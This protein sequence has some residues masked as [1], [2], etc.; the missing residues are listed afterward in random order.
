MRNLSVPIVLFTVVIALSGCS[1]ISPPVMSPSPTDV[2]SVRFEA[3]VYEVQVPEN[4]IAELDA[5][6]FEAH[7]AT[8]QNLARLLEDFGETK[9]LYK[10]DKVINIYGDSIVLETMRPVITGGSVRR[11]EQSANTNPVTYISS[12]LRVNVAAGELRRPVQLEGVCLQVI[13]QLTYMT[14]S[15]AKDKSGRMLNVQLSQ[16]E[17]LKFGKP[18]VLLNVITQSGVDDAKP[19][20]YVIYY[21]FKEIKP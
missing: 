21:V 19:E 9:A 11:S 3:T 7:A 13:F 15:S 17:K 14:D 5:Q 16:S 12:G 2:A 10:V 20:T 1:T 6:V 8:Q 4:R 18:S